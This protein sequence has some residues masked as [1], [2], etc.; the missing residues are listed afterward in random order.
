MLH[1]AAPIMYGLSD[2]AWAC[3]SVGDKLGRGVSQTER[4]NAWCILGTG[5]QEVWH[6]S[7]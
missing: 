6:E 7:G 2:S 5:R 1:K 3:G 4:E